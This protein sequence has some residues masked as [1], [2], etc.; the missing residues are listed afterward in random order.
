MIF[1]VVDLI[2][3]S[4]YMYR[5]YCISTSDTDDIL[6]LIEPKRKKDGEGLAKSR[7]T[8]AGGCPFYKQD[9][10]YDLRDRAMVSSHNGKPC[11]LSLDDLLLRST[12]T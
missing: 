4:M 11:V 1:S 3:R 10:M 9:P 12:K 7:K 8:T 5:F 6:S 2:Y